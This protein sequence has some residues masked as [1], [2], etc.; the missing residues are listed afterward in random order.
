[1]KV[2]V[3]LL[4]DGVNKNRIFVARKFI[5]AFGPKRNSKADEQNGFDQHD[6]KFQMRGD[7]ALH[8]FMIGR[9][10]ADSCENGSGRK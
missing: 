3:E 6:G 1:M 8:A 10:M 4:T 7:A 9:R 2:P 5:H